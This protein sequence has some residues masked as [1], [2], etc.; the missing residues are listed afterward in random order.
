MPD[1]ISIDLEISDDGANAVLSRAEQKVDGFVNKVNGATPKINISIDG[2]PFIELDKLEKKG[3]TVRKTFTSLVQF[4]PRDNS[5]DGLSQSAIRLQQETTKANARVRET[6]KILSEYK[7]SNQSLFK[8]L[9]EDARKAEQE[10]TRLGVRSAELEKRLVQRGGMPNAVGGGNNLNF[11]SFQKQNLFYQANDIATMAAL[12][13]NPMQILASQAGQIAQIP[14][15]A[16]ASAL[17]AAYAPLVGI[18]GAGAAALLLT[19]KI[20]GDLRAEA[21]KRLKIETMITAA[22]NKQVLDQEKALKNFEESEKFAARNRNFSQFLGRAEISELETRKR[23]LEERKN[24][25]P[26]EFKGEQTS[27]FQAITSEI[28]AIN[29]QID[30]LRQR[31]KLEADRGFND[32][33]EAWKRSQESA[34]QASERA[35]QAAERAAKKHNEEVEKGKKFIEDLGKTSMSF[36]DGL[37]SRTG[38]NNP[39]VTLFS[40]ADRQAKLLRESTRGLS[41]DFVSQLEEM[42]A[43]ANS[44]KLF[45]ARVDNA[46]TAFGY[47][48]RAD[49][50]R[51]AGNPEANKRF[52]DDSVKS[53]I[54]RGL[55]F[56]GGAFGTYG[57]NLAIGAGADYDKLTDAQK[58]SI[59]EVDQLKNL[60]SPN[61]NFNSVLDSNVNDRSLISR[62]ARERTFGNGDENLSLND[63]LKKQYDIIYGNAFSDDEKAI[64]DRKFSALTNSVDFSKVSNELR[65]KAIIANLGAEKNTIEAEKKAEI[66]AQKQI[67]ATENLTKEI[68]RL[69]EIAERDGFGAVKNIVEIIDKS[70]GSVNVRGAEPIPSDMNRNYN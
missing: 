53:D 47:R 42:E 67:T 24:L 17:V 37:Y 65:E 32:R 60:Q 4:N 31:N 16:Q 49:Q 9:T 14:T 7:G 44:L 28:S 57:S 45:E 29:S 23:S 26:N 15:A 58:R 33:W 1:F 11:S 55:F 68:K 2:K 50:I 34:M 59:Y 25:F 13:A 64:A 5:L 52:F 70:N 36:L 27:E 22:G 30:A 3:E 61:A 10:L 43:K 19:Y 12:G 54:R 56:D 8:I 18:L 20:T 39:F 66:Q 35:W 6:Q 62:L 38:S 69:N 40:E 51:N 41:A 21:E 48:D 63:R 46:L